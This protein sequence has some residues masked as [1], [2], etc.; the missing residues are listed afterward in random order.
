M[1][2]WGGGQTGCVN[3]WLY[4][5]SLPSSGFPSASPCFRPP[6][7]HRWAAEGS[8]L[9]RGLSSR[10]AHVLHARAGSRPA[11]VQPREPAGSHCSSHERPRLIRGP[12][13]G[14][15]S[16]LCVL[17]VER[18]R[19][20]IWKCVHLASS[21]TFHFGKPAKENT[22]GTLQTKP[23]HWPSGKSLVCKTGITARFHGFLV[24]LSEGPSLGAPRNDVCFGFIYL[25]TWMVFRGLLRVGS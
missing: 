12:A 10:L 15:S 2:A 4:P 14:D 24:K 6:R 16:G 13:C 17:V 11:P 8:R 18:E 20:E 5:P 19:L 25:L 9:P 7:T 21:C 3:R 1:E 23:T 22:A